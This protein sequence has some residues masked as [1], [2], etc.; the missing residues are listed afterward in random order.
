MLETIVTANYL[1][2]IRGFFFVVVKIELMNEHL[3]W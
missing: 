1:K 3:E 2:I